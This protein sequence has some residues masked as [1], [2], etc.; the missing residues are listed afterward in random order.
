[1]AFFCSLVMTGSGSS[2][3]AGEQIVQ[4][5][6]QADQNGTVERSAQEDV[7]KI[8]LRGVLQEA[9]ELLPGTLSATRKEALS[10]VLSSRAGEYVLS[11]S[12]GKA[13]TRP[14]LLTT[15]WR[16]DV[17]GKRLKNSLK[18]WGVYFTVDE[19]LPYTLDLQASSP[20]K[21]RLAVDRLE[22]LSGLR[23]QAAAGPRLDLEQIK[24]QTKA[25]RG[26]LEVGG[27]SWSRKGSDLEEVWL[28]LWA[29][30]FSLQEVQARVLEDLILVVNGWS[31]VTGVQGFDRVLA[32][33]SAL[34]DRAVLK[35][36]DLLVAS[37][38][39]TWTIQTPDRTALDRFL[40]GYL[41]PRGLS[42][43]LR[44]VENE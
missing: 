17:N 4:V 41:S 14:G 10:S 33:K 30:Y 9:I 3:W 29:N 12:R 16:V 6:L 18:S 42:Y 15:S 24:G 2:L 36:S 34:V 13:E 35:N 39:G 26:R 38:Q 31:S 32:Q 8:L 23:S 5:V 40:N 11:Y 7:Q 1:M 25:W 28:G 44:K 20:Q 21:A 43:R 27:R 37:V 19:Q 22:S